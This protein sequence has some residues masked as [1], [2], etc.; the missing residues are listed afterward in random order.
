MAN[1]FQGLIE[2]STELQEYTQKRPKE[3]EI[4]SKAM[5]L[6]RAFSKHACAFV[7]SDIPIS[8][9]I[10]TKEGN[11]TQYEAKEC[12][13]A[14]LIKYDF[15]VVKQLKDIRICLDLINKKN[16]EKNVVG[17]FSHNGKK[18]YIWDLPE[19]T[20]SFHFCLGRFH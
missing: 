3:W 13:S 7:L 5:G 19:T 10:P 14:G 11:I 16:G 18:M 6:T 12:E 15:L 20:R 17:D 4:V 8:D 9:V 2:Q 1:I